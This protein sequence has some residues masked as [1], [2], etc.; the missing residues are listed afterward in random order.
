MLQ[1]QYYQ[2]ALESYRTGNLKLSLIYLKKLKKWDRKSIE[3]LVDS[4][5]DLWKQL[6][7]SDVDD[8]EAAQVVQ[9]SFVLLLSSNVSN[10]LIA[11]WDYIRLSHVYIIQGNLVGASEIMNIA[12]SK[13]HMED[14][15]IVSQSCFI[16]NALLQ[17]KEAQRIITF[18]ASSLLELSTKTKTNK[19]DTDSY[20]WQNGLIPYYYLFILSATFL[21]KRDKF[22]HERHKQQTYRDFETLIRDG[23]FFANLKKE[24]NLS[25]LLNWYNDYFMWLKCGEAL[26][27]GP[28]LLIA[29]AFYWEAY[30]RAPLLDIAIIKL[31][32][33]MRT[34]GR[35]G[36]IPGMLANALTVNQ[37][38]TVCRK[39]I[40]EIEASTVIDPRD[41]EWSKMFDAESAEAVKIQAQVRGWSLRRRWP[42]MLPHLVETRRNHLE[43]MRLADERYAIYIEWY[44]RQLVHRWKKYIE[45]WKELKR[46]SSTRLQSV[47]RMKYRVWIYRELIDR[48]KTANSNYFILCQRI[49][50]SDRMR[51]IRRW[52]QHYMTRKKYQAAGV[53]ADFLFLNGYNQKLVK[54]MNE[55]LS[56]LRVYYKHIRKRIWRHWITRYRARQK[57]HARVTIRFWLR[58]TMT[59]IEERL[60]E[61][62]LKQVEQAV[63]AKQEVSFERNYLPLVRTMFAEWLR[64][65]RD[66]LKQRA[67]LRMVYT[68]Q[69]RFYSKKA[70]EIVRIKALR[71]E[72]QRA[73]WTQRRHR[74]L[75]RIIRPWLLNAAALRM[76][77]FVRSSFAM[78][79]FRR[80]RAI[81]NGVKDMLARRL[82]RARKSIIWRWRKYVYLVKREQLRA[83]RH[84]LFTFRRVVLKAKL[85]RI[86]LRKGKLYRFV[87]ACHLSM[88]GAYFRFIRDRAKIESRMKGAQM[89][90]N[91]TYQ[92]TTLR[93]I[94]RWRQLLHVQHQIGTLRRLFIHRPLDRAFW[95]GAH[96]SVEVQSHKGSSQ[97]QQ[98]ADAGILP[99]QGGWEFHPWEKYVPARLH[100]LDMTQFQQAKAF[101]AWMAVYRRSQQ[102]RFDGAYYQA[103]LFQNELFTH[104]QTRAVANVQIQ[105]WFRILKGRRIRERLEQVVRWA[106]ELH[107]RRQQRRLY[108]CWMAVKAMITKRQTA[109]PV[110]V[111]ALRINVAKSK[112]NALRRRFEEHQALIARI[113]TSLFQRSLARKVLHRWIVAYCQRVLLP[114]YSTEKLFQPKRRRGGVTRRQQQQQQASSRSRAFMSQDD[115][116]ISQASSAMAYSNDDDGDDGHNM[117]PDDLEHGRGGGGGS[118]SDDDEDLNPRLRKLLKYQKRLQQRQSNDQQQQQHSAARSQSMSSFPSIGAQSSIHSSGS[119]STRMPKDRKGHH[120]KSVDGVLPTA[121]SR[122]VS[123]SVMFFRSEHF[124][125]ILQQVRLTQLF[126]YEP[127]VAA[128]LHEQEVYFLLQHATVVILKDWNFVAHDYLR[129]YQQAI[130]SVANCLPWK[131]LCNAFR[132][133]RVVVQ[134]GSVFIPDET[135]MYYHST[136]SAEERQAIIQRRSLWL[137]CMSD[138]IQGQRLLYEQDLIDRAKWPLTIPS[139][140]LGGLAGPAP[141]PAFSNGLSALVMH[142]HQMSVSHRLVVCVVRMLLPTAIDT[143]APAVHPRSHSLES[144]SGSSASLLVPAVKGGGGG[145]LSTTSTTSMG[146]IPSFSLLNKTSTLSSQ[147]NDRPTGSMLSLTSIM[148]QPNTSVAAAQSSPLV[149][150]RGMIEWSVDF[151][152]VGYLGIVL[153]M[154]AVKVRLIVHGRN[155]LTAIAFLIVQ[156]LSHRHAPFYEG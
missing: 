85:R 115:D 117:D 68:L 36:D 132:G 69:H 25:V 88:L 11:P 16:M 32:D 41:R 141:A 108:E 146:R 99:T 76:Q 7:K 30:L 92:M 57:K 49:F 60:Q 133:Q 128:S 97:R 96:V 58:D 116:D 54:G 48:V 105:T 34:Y 106:V 71:R 45:D 152:S 135:D 119:G 151:D 139:S 27:S 23:Y 13:G 120:K 91:V 98:Q 142:W 5:Y 109:W 100:L 59:R 42:G 37:W 43:K 44:N 153:V 75:V 4:S 126:I 19:S 122:Y 101:R 62:K 124:H 140:A 129:Q 50:V 102:F 33:S 143:F 40:R 87:Q 145:A 67:V 17:E 61:A 82:E 93:T 104:L 72:A 9:E 156:S 12:S 103:R 144:L 66:R 114:T 89:V 74:L 52:Q 46:V 14:M 83:I 113:D 107:A 3:L 123:S 29:E 121:L 28:F 154:M 8:T 138:L 31:M 137:Q 134:G 1:A 81:E 110:V 136:Y 95:R 148:E 6:A 20:S 35:E 78:R 64:K 63:A 84:V 22:R 24:T 70:R 26:D 112:L 127:S 90:L 47:W 51:Y 150:T 79:K 2:Q 73:F 55:V 111:C 10:D 149:P 15:L 38:N 18:M 94:Q 77:R 125:R 155:V 131:R 80:L 53:I 118:G 39:S 130:A 86:G 56:V 21:Q 65:Y 147:L